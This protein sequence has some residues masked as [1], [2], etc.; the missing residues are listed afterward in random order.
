MRGFAIAKSELPVI[1]VNGSRANSALTLAGT[2]SRAELIE[3]AA[4]YRSPRT[5]YEKFSPGR[6][7]VPTFLTGVLGAE[8]FDRPSLDEKNSYPRV[9]SRMLQI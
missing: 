5:F 8:V 2:K 6:R 4:A 3:F 7:R 1:V 9:A